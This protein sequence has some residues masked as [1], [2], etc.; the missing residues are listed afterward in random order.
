MPPFVSQSRSSGSGVWSGREVH[1]ILRLFVISLEKL[2]LEVWAG[3]ETLFIETW[4]LSRRILDYWRNIIGPTSDDFHNYPRQWDF[5]WQLSD[6]TIVSHCWAKIGGIL[7]TNTKLQIHKYKI[8]NTE[9]KIQIHCLAK[10]FKGRC[11]FGVCTRL[12]VLG[13]IL[14][15]RMTIFFYIPVYLKLLW[16]LW[17]S[18]SRKLNLA[19]K[20]DLLS[21]H[22]CVGLSEWQWC[23]APTW[24]EW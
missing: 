3:V 1:L 11:K 13:G 14:D 18:F 6:K 8:T 19:S 12:P 2:H 10:I 16:R 5:F 4:T 7:S 22:F 21:Q 20:L 24:Q 15:Q 23:Q 9:I 17:Q